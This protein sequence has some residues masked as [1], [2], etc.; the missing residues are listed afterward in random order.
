[1]CFQASD[2]WSNIKNSQRHLLVSSSRFLNRYKVSSCDAL[3]P[4]SLLSVLL[5]LCLVDLGL[6]VNY[7]WGLE[8]SGLTR[9]RRWNGNDAYGKCVK[10][11]YANVSVFQPCVIKCSALLAAHLKDCFFNAHQATDVQEL[12]KMR[13]YG[14]EWDKM[15]TDLTL[16]TF[17]LVHRGRMMN[18]IKTRNGISLNK[19]MCVQSVRLWVCFG[20]NLFPC[21]SDKLMKW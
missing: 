18:E 20:Y 3:W 7:S 4:S 12:P 13:L 15:T 8:K 17:W 5:F 9:L 16:E 6:L 1:M 14:G 2:L 19:Q 10:H 21:T 11:L